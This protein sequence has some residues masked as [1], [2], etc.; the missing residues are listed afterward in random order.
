MRARILLVAAMLAGPVP[1]AWAQFRSTPDQDQG[2]GRPA[3]TDLQSY[4]TMLQDAENRL[5]QAQQEATGAPTQRQGGAVS[6]QRV[7][8][9]QVAR[10]AQE[11]LHRAPADFMGTDAYKTADREL[12]EALSGFISA[13][14]EGGQ[15][16]LQAADRAVQILAGLRQQVMQAAS[17]SGSG[18]ATPPAAGTGR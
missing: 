18:G 4:A 9:S 14:R 13:Q 16:S 5:R 11:S 10:G 15:G 8:L 2:T 6:Q 12:R 17:A 7:E 3:A 1:G